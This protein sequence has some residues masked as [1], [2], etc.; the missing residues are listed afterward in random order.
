[1]SRSGFLPGFLPEEFLLMFHLA[2]DCDYDFSFAMFSRC[3]R[4][5][6]VLASIE[7]RKNAQI[8]GWLKS[9]NLSMHPMMMMAAVIVDFIH[10][11]F[12][13]KK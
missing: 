4:R 12:F 1:M 10:H 8:C 2:L 6:D 3:Q 9:R 5:D 7:R 13:F 11:V